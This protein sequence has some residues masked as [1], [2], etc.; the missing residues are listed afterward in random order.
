MRRGSKKAGSGS[1]PL[2]FSFTQHPAWSD[3]P[4][5]GRNLGDV[6][7]GQIPSL[8]TSP[9]KPRQPLPTTE[10]SKYGGSHP[11]VPATEEVTEGE[12]VAL[13]SPLST[14]SFLNHTP[15]STKQLL[16]WPSEPSDVSPK[17]VDE[18]L[19]D[20]GAPHYPQEMG[21][22]QVQKARGLLQ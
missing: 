10:V 17:S 8:N 18:I 1:L 12:Q 4:E 22:S 3:E 21:L 16:L 5:T 2:P 6:V 13:T 14:E 11:A 19:W 20:G 7:S 9:T 15:C